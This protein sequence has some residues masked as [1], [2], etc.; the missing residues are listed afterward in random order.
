MKLGS[1]I[2]DAIRQLFLD[3]HVDIFQIDGELKLAGSNLLSDGTQL[4]FDG[5]KLG[6]I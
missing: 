1:G 4:L 2:A 5:G 6:L 3:I